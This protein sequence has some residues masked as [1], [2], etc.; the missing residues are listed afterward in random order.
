MNEGIYNMRYIGVLR[1]ANL[2]ITEI[3]LNFIENI[4]IKQILYY[5]LSSL[6]QTYFKFFLEKLDCLLNLKSKPIMKTMKKNNI[7]VFLFC[8]EKLWQEI[9]TKK[10]YYTDIPQ[11]YGGE[12]QNCII[13]V[14]NGDCF[15]A[16]EMYND[17]VIHNFANNTHP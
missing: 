11:Q 15:V 5:L 17:S 1:G 13:E 3:F 10:Y 12:K 16:A 6:E 7:N 8:K 2:K 14:F 9:T 4:A